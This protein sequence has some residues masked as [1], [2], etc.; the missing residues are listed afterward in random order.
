MTN[1][2]LTVW[3]TGLSGAGKST[4]ARAVLQALT[5]RGVAA[6]LLDAD[7]MRRHLSPG[8]GF[9]RAEREENVRR[10]GFV[11]EL[12]AKNG[13]VVLVAAMSPYRAGR[14]ERT[15]R[16]RNQHPGLALLDERARRLPWG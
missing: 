5:E 9:T 2:A 12:L 8:L 3:L 11:A 15:G 10:L 16:S 4:L 13:I 14:D 6:E 1:R 7:Q